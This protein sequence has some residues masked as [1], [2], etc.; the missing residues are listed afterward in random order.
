MIEVTK[1]ASADM[2]VYDVKFN[3]RR[4]IDGIFKLVS[5]QRMKRI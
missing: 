4:L 3:M 2:P 5:R 1:L